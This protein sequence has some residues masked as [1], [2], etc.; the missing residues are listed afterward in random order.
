MQVHPGIIAKTVI[1]LSSYINTVE[2]K[3]DKYATGNV[4]LIQAKTHNNYMGV[5]STH[6]THRN[7]AGGKPT[8]IMMLILKYTVII[9]HIVIVTSPAGECTHTQ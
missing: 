1:A 8:H 7:L 4:S 9:I 2:D 3:V 6:F 5:S